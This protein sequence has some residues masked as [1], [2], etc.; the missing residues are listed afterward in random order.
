MRHQMLGF[1]F[2]GSGVT[3]VNMYSCYIKKE[4][5]GNEGMLTMLTGQLELAML[6][7]FHPG[8]TPGYM[9]LSGHLTRHDC[10]FAKNP[11]SCRLPV[12]IR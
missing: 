12:R 10:Q 7:V 8:T 11:M 4:K 2:A 6:P 3:F 5:W 1:T 9:I